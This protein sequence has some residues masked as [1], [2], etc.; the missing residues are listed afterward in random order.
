MSSTSWTSQQAQYKMGQRVVKEKTGLRRH[1]RQCYEMTYEQTMSAR[2]MQD[3]L[4]VIPRS[5]DRSQPSV[6]L[7]TWG[8][9]TQP[10][11]VFLNNVTHWQNLLCLTESVQYQ[12]T[13]C[14]HYQSNVL[15]LVNRCHAFCWCNLWKKTKT[16]GQSPTCIRRTP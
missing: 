11:N 13:Y 1:G 16:L 12:L 6:S 4:L 14:S 10:S 9:K 7:E 8:P 3:L 5:R 15:H 2:K